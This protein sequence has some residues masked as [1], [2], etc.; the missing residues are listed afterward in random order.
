MPSN[1]LFLDANFPIINADD[2][3]REG[4]QKLQD[5]IYQQNEQLRYALTHIGYENFDS[6][7]ENKFLSIDGKVLT[8]T[9]NDE[10]I[11]AVLNNQQGSIASLSATVDGIRTEVY[12]IEPGSVSRITAIEQTAGQIS[13]EVSTISGSYISR[14]GFTQ[15]DNNFSFFITDTAQEG[16]S[17]TTKIEMSRHGMSV[18]DGAIAIYGKKN[19]LGYYEANLWADSDGNLHLV[20]DITARSLTLSGGAKISGTDIQDGTITTDKLSAES[21]TADKIK[22][23]GN[24]SVYQGLYDGAPLGGYLGYAPSN[25]DPSVYGMALTSNRTQNYYTNN[26]TD[27]QCAVTGAGARLSV[28][29]TDSYGTYHTTLA[30]I[31]ASYYESDEIGFAALSAYASGYDVRYTYDDGS[32]VFAPHGGTC[33][34][35][36]PSSYDSRGLSWFAGAYLASSTMVTSDRNLKNSISYDLSAYDAVFDALKPAKFR[37]NDGTSG[38][39]HTGFI[40]QDVEDAVVGAGLT[41]TDFAAVAYNTDVRGNKTYFMRNEELIA[42]CVDRIHKLE[43]RIAI[44][45]GAA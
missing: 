20:G 11:L 10:G 6:D 42:L 43:A 24:M 13:S 7:T 19:A 14:T 4:I 2:D 26:Y 16:A 32:M 45:E 41:L 37:F 40:A 9:A 12:G 27:G 39:F 8:L 5:F 35:G 23:G 30:Q 38:R 36:V 21:V 3:V 17:P 31:Y 22:L 29:R 33:Y 44:L 34:L 25:N 15:T 18:Y 1:L 28:S